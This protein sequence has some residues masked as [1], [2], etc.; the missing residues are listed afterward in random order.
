MPVKIAGGVATGS[1]K[2]LGSVVREAGSGQIVTHLRE[3]ALQ[4]QRLVGPSEMLL[5]FGAVSSI[6]NLGATVAFGVATLHKLNKIDAKLE[7]MEDS[8][9]R[10]EGTVNRI[11]SVLNQCI[12][13]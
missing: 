6:I 11:E 8:L 13:Q 10:I 12:G 4:P 3:A 2:R 9:G 7:R 1:L 5:G